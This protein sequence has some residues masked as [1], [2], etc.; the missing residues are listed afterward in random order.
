MPEYINP[1]PFIVHLAGPDGTVTKV[2]PH[3]KITLTEY[4]D[5]YVKRGFIKK[6]GGNSNNIKQQN[7]IHK[8]LGIRAELNKTQKLKPADVKAKPQAI[9]LSQQA[10]STQFKN[11]RQR[12]ARAKK[13][14]QNKNTKLTTK[15]LKRAAKIVGRNL[16]ENANALL[17]SNL[18]EKYFPISNNIG[19]GILSY[20]RLDCLKRLVDSILRYTDLRK[21]TIF[22][23]DDASDDEQLR[24]Y[25]DHLS[26]TGDFVIIRNDTRL[27]VAGNSNRLIRCLSRFKCG[28]LLNDDVEVLKKGWEYFYAQAMRRTKMHH[29]IYRQS[30]VYG[31]SKGEKLSK[32]GVAINRVNERPHGAVL[33]FSISMVEKCGY[34]NEDYGIYGM[35]HVDWSSKAHEFG[36]QEK[37]FY[38]VDGSDLYFKLHN[39]ASAVENR[40]THLKH[41]R[42]L[43]AGRIKKLKIEPTLDSRVDDMTY[44]V[45]FRDF[46]RTKSISTV[47]NNIRAQRL[48]VINIVVVEQDNQA[49]L[50]LEDCQPV[51]YLNAP[52]S[53]S[54]LF[55]K[56]YAFNVGV[57]AALSDKIILHDAD[58][59]TQGDYAATINDILDK[60]ESCHIGSRVIYTD[61]QS[62]DDIN[63]R[64]EVSEDVKCER[65]VGYFEGGSLACTKLAYWKCGGFNEDFWGYGCE[66]CDFYKIISEY[67]RWLE[68]R[69]YD[70]LHL[71]H[72]RVSGWNQYH[73]INKQIESRLNK[74]TVKERVDRQLKQLKAN[75]YRTLLEDMRII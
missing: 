12:I 53:D 37:G 71:W 66:D 65:V 5:V 73:D 26:Q 43:F 68:D 29:F 41:A 40:E 8:K 31:A 27:G 75:G 7:T 30:G 52:R 17:R 13:I 24:E 25:L 6:V 70:F 62:C 20:E 34:F 51:I 23:S 72:S 49:C 36:L 45:P 48:P 1:N 58:M 21:T 38:D 42:K 57:K 60:Y 39:V 61:Q 9:P 10:S 3:A 16:G 32:L 28:L 64:G 22:I 63:Q 33:A 44:V 59:I 35:E 11:R 69:S 2:K 74:L 54:E 14:T 56:S 19:V 46:E 67:A 55:N 18:D 15:G 4:Y 47:V 50:D